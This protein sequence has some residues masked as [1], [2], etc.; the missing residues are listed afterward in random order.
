MDGE[1]SA[2]HGHS[3]IA[4]TFG[5]KCTNL[6]HMPFKFTSEGERE[7]KE[8]TLACNRLSPQITAA[9]IPLPKIRYKA[10]LNKTGAGNV[11]MSKH[12]LLPTVCCEGKNKC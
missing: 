12:S 8:G 2:P 4:A 10:N 7:R 9:Y 1:K 5:F 11:T 3:G 6:Q